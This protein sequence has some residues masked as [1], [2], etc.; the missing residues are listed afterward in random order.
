LTAEADIPDIRV[1]QEILKWAKKKLISQE[2]NKLLLAI[3]HKR[4]IAWHGVARR[5]K[6]EILQNIWDLAEEDLTR[7]EIHNKLLFATDHTV[8]SVLH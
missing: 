8:K 7:W 1:L 5:L 6:P 4:M 3:D 2:I